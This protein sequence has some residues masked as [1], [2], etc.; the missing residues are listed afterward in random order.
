MRVFS[1]YHQIDKLVEIRY[2]ARL[3]FDTS[4]LGE[5]SKARQV[6]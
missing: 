2:Q 6:I 3:L 5:L 1:E 4:E